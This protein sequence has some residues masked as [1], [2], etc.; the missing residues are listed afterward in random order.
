MFGA[1]VYQSMAAI[2][3][4][5]I[6]LFPSPGHSQSES[7]LRIL[8]V[9]H[10][11]LRNDDP[12]ST[13]LLGLG[14][15][16]DLIA[17]ARLRALAIL[18]ENNSCTAWFQQ[19]DPDPAGILR[20]VH[21]KVDPSGPSNIYKFRNYY[22]E[23]LLKHPWGAKSIEYAGRNALVRINGNGPFFVRSSGV[24]GLSLSAGPTPLSGW[25][26]L[27]VGPYAAATPEARIAVLLHELGHIV[28]RL[29]EDSDSTDGQSSR[30]TIE[31][32][33]HCKAEIH[34]VARRTSYSPN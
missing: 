18:Q 22:G 3:F 23:A 4:L 2:A 5:A 26:A 15:R 13:E 27:V 1:R 16:G 29:P 9:V 31:V 7:A 11:E 21:Y 30:N 17:D 28:G 8:S 34:L 14:Q 32:L 19:A 20:S 6:L 33:R 24:E 25:Q 10:S 12:V